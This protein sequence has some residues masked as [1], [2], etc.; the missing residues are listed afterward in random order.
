MTFEI[1][2]VDQLAESLGKYGEESDWAFDVLCSR[3]HAGVIFRGDRRQSDVHI[4]TREGSY[5]SQDWTTRR[6]VWEGF[7]HNCDVVGTVD[8]DC[9]GSM[10]SGW[11]DALQLG[12]KVVSSFETRVF[13]PEFA[14]LTINSPGEPGVAYMMVAGCSAGPEVEAALKPFGAIAHHRNHLVLTSLLE[15]LDLAGVVEY[16]DVL[17]LKVGGIPTERHIIRAVING[18]DDYFGIMNT[19]K[20]AEFWQSKLI[21]NPI[22][23][24]GGVNPDDVRKLVK[25]GGPAYVP[26]DPNNFATLDGLKAL[27]DAT[28]GLLTYCILDGQSP[29]EADASLM[30]ERCQALD[31]EA[32]N[33]I[34]WRMPTAPEA[35]PWADGVI[36]CA[37]REGWPCFGGSEMNSAGQVP[38]GPAKQFTFE[39][40]RLEDGADILYGLTIMRRACGES[41][42]SL[43]EKLGSRDAILFCREAGRGFQPGEHRLVDVAKAWSS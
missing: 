37:Y 9:L 36:D 11:E 20:I 7:H 15:Y 31:V 34:F 1:P 2:T 28:G 23:S 40:T 14:D 41:W 19:R 16:Q 18:V 3:R 6:V 35:K 29:F 24:D 30:F 13:L 26:I 5:N 17:D 42:R 8:F 33:F 21:G 38:F 43:V 39:Y 32:F 4:H 12:Q 25:V 27:A 10:D 22:V